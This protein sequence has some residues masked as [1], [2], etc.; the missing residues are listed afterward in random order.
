M[1]TGK[2]R[3]ANSNRLSSKILNYINGSNAA[4]M[5]L[6]TRS[7]FLQQVSAINYINYADNNPIAAARAFANYKQFYKDYKHLMN[8]EWA[9]NRRDGLRFSIA[10]SEILDL[11]RSAKNKAAVAI[12]YALSKGFIMTKYMDSHATAFGGASFYRNRINTYIKEGFTKQRAEQKAYK[13]WVEISEKT[14]QTARYDMVSM[15]Q[16]SVSGKLILNYNNVNLNYAKQGTKKQVSDLSNGRYDHFWKGNNSALAKV[17][18]VIYYNAMQSLLFHGLQKAYFKILFDD[19]YVMDTTEEEILNATLDSFLVGMGI[20][21]KVLA[22]FKNWM[23]KVNKESKKKRPDYADTLS[24]LLTI[25]PAIEK[26]FKM[27]SQALDLLTYNMDE[28]KQKGFSLDNPVL[29]VFAKT[30]EGA[31][32][33]PLDNFQKNIKNIND[34]L[35]AERAHWQRPW[36]LLGWPAWTFDKKQPKKKKR[37]TIGIDLDLDL[38]LDF[39]L[40]LY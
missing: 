14:Q 36:L 23:F 25:S 20:R 16:A 17:G 28:M 30:V 31:T 34:A 15:E 33:A 5:F 19:G 8:S 22:T 7:A 18:R 24:E 40:D 29:G 21:G 37:K 6:N 38:G 39:D 13:E 26:K 12:N 27:G 1:S 2:N 11:S 3:T 35:E 10:E 4:I 9:L 32:N